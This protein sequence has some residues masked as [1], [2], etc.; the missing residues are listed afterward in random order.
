MSEPCAYCGHPVKDEESKAV[1]Q[2]ASIPLDAL[3]PGKEANG[4][5]GIDRTATF[6][7]LVPM[8]ATEFGGQ[9]GIVPRAGAVFLEG[10]V[11]A[12]DKC[13]LEVAAFVRGWADSWKTQGRTTK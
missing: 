4:I 10:T 8:V 5:F 3:F 7:A 1:R 11:E 13:N 2:K 9:W 12:H 6:R